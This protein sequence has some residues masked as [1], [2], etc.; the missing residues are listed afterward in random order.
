M[1]SIAYAEKFSQ[2]GADK[3]I[4]GLPVRI[5]H[6][7]GCIQ[8]QYQVHGFTGNKRAK[9]ENKYKG[10]SRLFQIYPSR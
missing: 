9:G 10:D 4:A 6:T 8:E 5:A 1:E 7:G 3:I 2:E